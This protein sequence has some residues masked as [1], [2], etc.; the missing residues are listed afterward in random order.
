MRKTA[1]KFIFE[2][3]SFNGFTHKSIPIEHMCVD[4]KLLIKFKRS[5][6]HFKFSMN[7]MINF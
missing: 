6:S 4:E 5:H 1:E 3:I 7:K 2:H